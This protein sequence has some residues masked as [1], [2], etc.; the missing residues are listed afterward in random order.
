MLQL[1]E[2]P[3]VPIRSDNWRPTVYQKTPP[4]SIKAVIHSHCVLEEICEALGIVQEKSSFT[5]SLVSRK[6]YGL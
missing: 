6:G 2:Y 4:S 3:P 1:S 5:S